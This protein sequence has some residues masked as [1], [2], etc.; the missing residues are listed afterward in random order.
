MPEAVGECGVQH[1]AGLCRCDLSVSKVFQSPNHKNLEGAGPTSLEWCLCDCR[2]LAS[3]DADDLVKTST[4]TK[5]Q[6]MESV[7]G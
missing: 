5:I 3:D 1:Q 2:I 7:V 6:D 4:L